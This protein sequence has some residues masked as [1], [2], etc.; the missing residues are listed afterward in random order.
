ML[1]VDGE[2]TDGGNA[3]CW[4]AGIRA[5]LWYGEK[6]P[7]EWGRKLLFPMFEKGDAEID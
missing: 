2:G 4:E 6:K 7:W 3:G 5:R 1:A